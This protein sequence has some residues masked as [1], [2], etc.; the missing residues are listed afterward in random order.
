[1]TSP[2]SAADTAAWLFFPLGA[3]RLALR[4]DDVVRVRVR[5]SADHA[6]LRSALLR[7]LRIDQAGVTHVI[8]LDGAGLAPATAAPRVATRGVRRWSL[9]PGVSHLREALDGVAEC[10]EMGTAFVVSAT[11]LRSLESRAS[12]DVTPSGFDGIDELR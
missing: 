4:L 3:H 6:V 1:M 10:P 7:H 11:G 2:A 12:R 8:E 9:P 5:G